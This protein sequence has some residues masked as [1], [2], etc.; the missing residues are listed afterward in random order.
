MPQTSSS[1]KG[2][3]EEIPC[4]EIA[5]QLCRLNESGQRDW[6]C[7]MSPCPSFDLFTQ[8]T[9]SL[10]IGHSTLEGPLALAVTV[11]TSL[12]ESPL[13]SVSPPD[14]RITTPRKPNRST[15]HS[16]VRTARVLHLF[17]PSSRIHPDDVEI[18]LR[19]G[20]SVSGQGFL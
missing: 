16:T 2:H 18:D 1:V 20:Y 17:S 7:R 4:R 15:D 12:P 14:E 9:G 19:F 10:Q 6:H 13:R 8:L 5:W 11:P 3:D